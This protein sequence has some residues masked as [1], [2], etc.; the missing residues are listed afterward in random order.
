G[1]AGTF[2]DM[3]GPGT[4]TRP[5]AVPEPPPPPAGPKP[6]TYVVPPGWVELPAGGFRAAAFRITEGDRKAEVT[7]VPL[8]GAA[9]GLLANVNR[10]RQQLKLPETTEEQV[11]REAKEIEVAGARATYIDLLGPES[12]GAARERTLAVIVPRGEQT[13]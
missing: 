4:N 6:L 7:V 3:T 1:V 10:W 9:G 13:W 8:G 11:R 12:G 5:A 2:V